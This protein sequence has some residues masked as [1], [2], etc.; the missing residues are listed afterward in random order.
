MEYYL[1]Q[2]DRIVQYTPKFR[3]YGITVPDGTNSRIL[4]TF[5]PW[6]AQPLPKG[7]RDVWFSRLEALGIDPT[8]KPTV[9]SE[10][11]TDRWWK[12]KEH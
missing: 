3:E 2:E 6:C 1:D 4:I 5:C 9:P 12:N 11:R 10:F 7:L 8:V